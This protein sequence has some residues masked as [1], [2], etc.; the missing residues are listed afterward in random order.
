MLHKVFPLVKPAPLSEIVQ[1]RDA[2]I[3]MD[4]GMRA[5]GWMYPKNE[6]WHRIYRLWTLTTL[7]CGLCFVPMAFFGS[8]FMDLNS[9]TP[10]QFINSVQV[11]LNSCGSVFKVTFILL[12]IWRF[13]QA[14]I[15]LDRL[16]KRCI[17]DDQ[18]A[19]V[20]QT[21]ANCNMV[22][23]YFQILYVLYIISTFLGAVLQ[24]EMAWKFY[25]PLVNW[26]ESSAKFWTS[27]FIELFMMSCCVFMQQLADSYPIVYMLIIRGHIITLKMR[28]TQ[29]RSDL[30]LSEPQNYAELM[31]CIDDHRLIIM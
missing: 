21:V 4:R 22:Y 30:E 25:N 2:F 20:H 14:N 7:I 5:A 24:G 1:S 26:R 29:L 6:H 16:D 27:A 31:K 19:K 28:I 3:Y 11:G 17:S 23:M 15:L 9:F 8:Y 13:E 18:R 12:G 10:A